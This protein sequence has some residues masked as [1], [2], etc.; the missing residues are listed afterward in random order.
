MYASS[1]VPPISLRLMEAER[2]HFYPSFP[3][4][5]R[6]IKPLFDSYRRQLISEYVSVS[7]TVL[8][9]MHISCMYISANIESMNLGSKNA[10]L[11]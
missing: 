3:S 1:V 6:I 10:I 4:L 5:E 8:Y 2:L 9:S 7:S 11:K